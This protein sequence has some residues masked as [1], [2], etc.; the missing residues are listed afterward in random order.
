MKSNSE[1]RVNRSAITI[2]TAFAALACVVLAVFWFCSA[3]FDQM[4]SN[5]IAYS[6]SAKNANEKLYT[7][8]GG[9]FTLVDTSNNPIR[10]GPQVIYQSA[11]LPSD[12]DPVEYTVVFKDFDGTVLSTATYPLGENV[13]LP[14]NPA[15]P[16]DAQYTYTFA[17]WDKDVVAV[18]ED[19]TYTATYTSTLNNYTVTW[20]VGAESFSEQIAYGSVPVFSGSTDKAEDSRYIYTF[21]G[22]DKEVVA[23]TEDVTYTAIYTETPKEYTITFK[24]YDDT[25]LLEVKY[26]YGETI[27]PPEDP[28]H[29]N[30]SEGT[31]RFTGWLPLVAE[32]CT[33][34]AVY[35]AVFERGYFFGDANG[36]GKVSI[37]DLL[38]IKSHIM[39]KKFLSQDFVIV[40]DMNGDGNVT[41]TDFLCVKDI[42]LGKGSITA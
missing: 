15:R 25:V 12:T 17:G 7:A 5:S 33:G 39:D 28:T 36:D 6:D 9:T 42:I 38:V 11:I 35:V 4:Q 34:D 32:T 20:V 18:T 30:D 37:S 31:F 23:V 10:T 19:V 21:S 14:A 1:K 13:E 8:L 40:A 27:V 16:A 41:I 2:I 29:P 26:T 24:N 3:R 22:W